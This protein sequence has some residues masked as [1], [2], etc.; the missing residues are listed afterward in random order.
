MNTQEKLDQVLAFKEQLKQSLLQKGCISEDTPFADYSKSLD[1]HLKG[2]QEYI[3]N[4]ISSYDSST[5]EFYSDAECI[6][7]YMFFSGGP[8]STR[9]LKKVEFPKAKVVGGY[10]FYGCS[11]ITELIFPEVEYVH[12][13]AFRNMSS[14]TTVILPKCKIVGWS[15]MADCSSLRYVDM[16]SLQHI[17]KDNMIDGLQ[18]YGVTPENDGLGAIFDGSG[19][20]LKVW[21]PHTVTKLGT[22]SQSNTSNPFYNLRDGSIYT[23]ATKGSTSSHF[24][25]PDG[26]SLSWTQYW[27]YRRT[28]SSSNMVPTTYGYTHAKFEALR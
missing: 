12:T 10:A 24:K 3:D 15:A 17:T 8:F 7:P 5:T 23:D 22:N 19:S 25:R 9:K 27:N 4:F 26:T 13:N 18:T 6:R 11:T 28:G 16:P 21:I 2:D 20:G 14:L 1:N